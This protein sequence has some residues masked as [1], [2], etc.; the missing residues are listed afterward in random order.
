MKIN[1]HGQYKQAQHMKQVGF[2]LIELMIVIAIVGILAAI[3]VPTYLN[4]V[5]RAQVSE[6]L[7]LAAE[8]Q[9]AIGESYALLGVL[10]A[11]NEEA[12]YHSP[13][14]VENIQSIMVG[15]QGK[16]I[17]T[18]QSGILMSGH[19][20]ITLTPSLSHHRIVGWVCSTHPENFKLVSRRC[21][22]DAV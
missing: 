7:S 13:E 16:V 14:H 18:F 15:A 19:D 5:R 22:H 12:T 1:Q 2:T 9:T 17:I 4:F 6:G 21:R 8:A 20:R 3:A 11:S 10:P